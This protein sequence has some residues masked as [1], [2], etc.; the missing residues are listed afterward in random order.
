MTTTGMRL[1]VLSACIHYALH[2]YHYIL[3]LRFFIAAG[4]LLTLLAV[5][6][7]RA[8]GEDCSEGRISQVVEKCK[9]ELRQKIGSNFTVDCT[10]GIVQDYVECLTE[11]SAC[12]DIVGTAELTLAQEYGFDSMLLQGAVGP[13]ARKPRCTLVASCC[14]FRLRLTC[15]RFAIRIG[16][17]GRAAE[18]DGFP[19]EL[20]SG[21]EVAS[22]FNCD[23][24]KTL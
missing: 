9:I 17:P 13:K 24:G 23:I 10:G 8:C 7:A 19:D 15:R 14:P 21:D 11:I 4:V 20:L 18:G 6:A 1:L 5:F 22:N 2:G 12:T 3:C 16:R